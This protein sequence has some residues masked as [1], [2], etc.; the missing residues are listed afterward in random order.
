MKDS[1][2]FRH[3]KTLKKAY[4][5]VKLAHEKTNA[6]SLPSGETSSASAKTF[7]AIK[8][9]NRILFEY[10][11][12]FVIIPPFFFFLGVMMLK[13]KLKRIREGRGHEP[14]DENEDL[15]SD[16]WR[17][18]AGMEDLDLVRHKNT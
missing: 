13:R 9:G 14:E 15:T 7:Q 2:E 1:V 8:C 16:A 17:S 11:F 3:F 18:A 4:L 10:I 5:E 6:N 12:L